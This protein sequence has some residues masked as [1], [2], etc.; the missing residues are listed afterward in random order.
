[1]QRDFSE[2][3]KSYTARGLFAVPSKKYIAGSKK[4]KKQATERD[5]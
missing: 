2:A 3:R 1:M 4:K 5:R